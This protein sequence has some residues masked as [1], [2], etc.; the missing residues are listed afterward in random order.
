MTDHTLVFYFYKHTRQ[1]LTI[2]SGH[3]RRTLPTIVCDLLTVW[4]WSVGRF[5]RAL[6]LPA[7]TASKT[8]IWSRTF[9]H[10]DK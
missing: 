8:A 4:L 9:C 3:A 7:L 5:H 10:F 6:R 2:Q 1:S